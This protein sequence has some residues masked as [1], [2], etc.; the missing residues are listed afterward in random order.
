[1]TT[2]ATIDAAARALLDAGAVAVRAVTV[3]RACG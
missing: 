1:M 2:G 3:A